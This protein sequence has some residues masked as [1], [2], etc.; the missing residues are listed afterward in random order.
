MKNHNLASPRLL[1]VKDFAAQ[2]G[3][4]IWTIRQ[5]AYSGRIA[6]VKFGR[7]RLMVPSTELDRIIAE[8]LR[9]A[10]QQ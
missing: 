7:G 5:W 2:S 6:S 8:N 9:P 10:V 1:P 4:S 3:F